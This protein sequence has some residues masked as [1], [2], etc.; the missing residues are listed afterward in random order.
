M[1]G[2]SAKSLSMKQM[3]H[4]LVF[5]MALFALAATTGCFS[6]VKYATDLPAEN[7]ESTYGD[8]QISGEIRDKWWESFDDPKLNEFV[9]VVLKESP[10]L[11]SAYLRLIDSEYALKQND[12]SFY[13][14]VTLNA[15]VGGN[16][17][18]YT[19]PSAQPSYNL[20]LS[21]S[22]EI[23][24]WGKVR[25]QQHIS[26]LTLL[27]A[28]D[29]A[30]SAAITLVGNV[31]TEWFNIKYYRDRKALIERLLLLSEEYY[32]LVQK[33]YR[34]GQT[35]GTDVLEQRQ[36]IETLRSN[37]RDLDVNIRLSQH[38]LEILAGRKVKP[39]VE[40]SLPEDVEM[41]GTID[42][43]VL[44]ENR[45]DIR[46]ARRSAQQADAQ[47]VVAIADR[48]PTLRLSAS[49]SYRSASIVDL[50]KTLLWDVGAS[51]S[52]PLFDGFKKTR[53]IDRAKASYLIQRLAY[54]VAV[55]NAISEVEKAILTLNL[56]EELLTDARSQLERQQEILDV[57]RDYFVNGSLDYSRVL[58]ALRSLISASQSEL[59]ARH[60]LINAQITL[61]KAM[62]G[63][64]WLK[65]TTEHNTQNARDLIKAL[66]EDNEDNHENND[67]SSD[68]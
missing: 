43:D 53:A 63:S 68:H 47:V 67:K 18:I 65:D 1:N 31:V 30:E 52:A 7:V 42:V 2:L 29:A 58:S 21:A 57:T 62:G 60:N 22:Y 45:P 13:P 35:T 40:G 33:H 37:I 20:G 41:G 3:A 28:Q 16:G 51:L 32:D 54:A 55:M 14:S 24:I 48:L 9:E 4:H 27:A 66:D 56:R 49:L 11:Q 39:E 6:P 12:S 10:S 25:A 8:I 46:S 38:A 44:L 23:D 64:G 59:E 15:G 26:E 50:F 17:V 36:Q 61:Y 19:D 5:W 34:Y